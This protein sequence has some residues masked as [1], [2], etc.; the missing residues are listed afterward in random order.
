MKNPEKKLILC[1]GEKGSGPYKTGT[2]LLVAEALNNRNWVGFDSDE[3]NPS[4][5]TSAYSGKVQRLP[6]TKDGSQ[7]L[8]QDGTVNWD[9][10][11]RMIE[12]L[13]VW[14]MSDHEPS[15]ALIDVGA[16][17]LRPVVSGLERIGMFDIGLRPTINFVVHDGSDSAGLLREAFEQYGGF[18]YMDWNIIKN[19]TSENYE[20]FD[21]AAADVIKNIAAHGGKIVEIPKLV[22]PRL[23][24]RW[25][26]ASP[27]VTMTDFIN[28]PGLMLAARL[29]WKSWISA[30][31]QAIEPVIE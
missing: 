9:G 7:P 14:M 15:I 1:S 25:R 28:D 13:G 29:R 19:S 5:A 16:N 11:D 4:F 27:R 3:R 26:E 23:Y 22:D 30:A 24:A 10:L 8:R 20:I 6:L 12:P 17:G 18:Q 31:I 2:T 21:H